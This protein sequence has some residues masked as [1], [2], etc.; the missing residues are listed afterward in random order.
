MA[1]KTTHVELKDVDGTGI[2]KEVVI[3]KRWDNGSYSFIETALLD[4]CD[5]G[6]LK[7]IITNAHA[8]KYEAWELCSQT[9]LNNGM[10]A[11][12]YFHQMTRHHQE[13]GSISSPASGL[14]SVA[15]IRDSRMIGSD[16]TNPGE[17]Q[18]TV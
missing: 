17:A 14:D 11:L 7:G 1:K 13:K 6:R 16:F 15:A 12:D 10:N 5:K 2:L 4:T 18:R 9:V 3:M 8:D